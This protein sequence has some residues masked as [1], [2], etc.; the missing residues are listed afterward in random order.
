[1]RFCVVSLS[2]QLS[3]FFIDL[4]LMSDEQPTASQAPPHSP[5]PINPVLHVHKPFKPNSRAAGAAISDQLMP[6]SPELQS[7]EPAGQA[8]LR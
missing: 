6:K 4:S 2:S 3:L 8:M 5:R 7:R 1:L